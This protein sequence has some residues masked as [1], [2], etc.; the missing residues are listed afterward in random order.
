MF[1]YGG[2]EVADRRVQCQVMDDLEVAA[3]PEVNA[4]RILPEVGQSYFLD[5]IHYSPARMKA[6][7]LGRLRVHEDALRS[8]RER[9]SNDLLEAPGS[10]ITV[11][12]VPSFW[13]G[14]VN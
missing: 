7:V 3:C 10:G 5:F 8:I 9:L 12:F 6:V 4:F 13:T 14:L 1:G 11:A 2:G